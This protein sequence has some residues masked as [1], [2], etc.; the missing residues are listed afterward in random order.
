MH[1]T[2]YTSRISQV[3]LCHIPASARTTPSM[4]VAQKTA[5][6]KR[7]TSTIVECRIMTRKL[8]KIQN[9]KAADTVVVTSQIQLN[10]FQ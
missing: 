5:I 6:P 8:L 9:I 7:N 10:R 2:K 3:V 4:A 1:S